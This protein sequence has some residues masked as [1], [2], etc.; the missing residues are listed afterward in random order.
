MTKE[1]L[2]KKL[3]DDVFYMEDEE[4]EKTAQRYLD[5]GYPA[6]DGIMEGLIDGMNRAGKLYE[7]EEYFITDIL[8]CSDALNAGLDVLKPHVK[9]DQKVERIKGVIGVVEG[10]THDIGKNLVKIMLEAG[11]FEMIDLGKD[12]KLER[13]VEVAQ[14][15]NAKFICMSTLMTTTM[16]GM[17]KVIDMLVDKGIRDEFKVMVGGG[18]VSSQFAKEIGADGYSEN[19]VEAV[20]LAKRLLAK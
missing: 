1:E 20:E 15:E 13:F 5:E 7:E 9:D 12:V 11:G 3:S 16:D 2:I 14:K 8:L 17:K 10:D 19:A 6:I 18:A 4:V